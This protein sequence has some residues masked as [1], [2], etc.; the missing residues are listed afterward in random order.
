[1]TLTTPP[2]STRTSHLQVGRFNAQASG[3]TT[4]WDEVA[5]TA[6]LMVRVKYLDFPKIVAASGSRK[7]HGR[8]FKDV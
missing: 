8:N 3:L 4:D 7:Y 2:L 1:M 5:Q 6:E